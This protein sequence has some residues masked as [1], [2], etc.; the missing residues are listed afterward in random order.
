[1]HFGPAGKEGK[2][3]R[4]GLVA[5]KGIGEI[6]VESIIKARAEGGPFK[7]LGDLCERV[8]GRTVNRKAL[9][10][11]IKSGACDCFGETR[12][13]LFASI[14]IALTRAAGIISDRQ[15]GQSSM[16]D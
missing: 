9:E 3:I 2:S 6:A 11:L 13:T 10:A 5:V 1:M 8:D 12:A 7:T 15:R 4:F 16:F 14:E